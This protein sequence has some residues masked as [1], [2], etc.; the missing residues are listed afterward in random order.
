LLQ[1]LQSLNLIGANPT[2][3]RSCQYTGSPRTGGPK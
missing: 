1:L 2:D 3:K